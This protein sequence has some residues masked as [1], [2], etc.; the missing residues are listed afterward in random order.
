MAACQGNLKPCKSKVLLQIVTLYMCTCLHTHTQ[1][2]IYKKATAN[3]KQGPVKSFRILLG[4]FHSLD[5]VKQSII[6]SVQ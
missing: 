5:Q 3:F 2:H 4:D 1:T 6:E